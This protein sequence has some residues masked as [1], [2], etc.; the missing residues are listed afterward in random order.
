MGPGNH[1]RINKKK[2][3][4]DPVGLGFIL[5]S[6]GGGPYILQFFAE[7][8]GQHP[9]YYQDMFLYYQYFFKKYDAHELYINRNTQCVYIGDK[10]SIVIK[11]Y[12][13]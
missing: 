12:I 10:Y 9:H 6:D 7:F 11:P 2:L 3:F 1:E 5:C 4:G 8:K 13:I